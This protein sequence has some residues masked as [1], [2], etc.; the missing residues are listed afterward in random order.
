MLKIS[1]TD[2]NGANYTLA[3][4]QDATGGVATLTNTAL[5]TVQT[6]N[7]PAEQ[8]TTLSIID[9]CEQLGLELPYSCRAGACTSCLCE[10][11]TGKENLDQMVAGEPIIDVEAN[12]FLACIGGCQKTALTDGAEHAAEIVVRGA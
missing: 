9:I 11:K 7:F 4:T 10:V 8:M 3:L 6:A 1:L 5:N 12:E 2:Q